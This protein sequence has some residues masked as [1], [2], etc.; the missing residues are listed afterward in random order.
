M[1]KLSKD[2]MNYPDSIRTLLFV[3]HDWLAHITQRDAK[4]VEYGTSLGREICRGGCH[5]TLIQSWT[6]KVISNSN[7]TKRLAYRHHLFRSISRSEINNP[8]DVDSIHTLVGSM[9]YPNVRFSSSD[10]LN[11]WSYLSDTPPL[12]NAMRELRPAIHFVGE[13]LAEREDVTDVR[14]DVDHGLLS[15]HSL[16]YGLYLVRLKVEFENLVVPDDRLS[17]LIELLDNTLNALKGVLHVEI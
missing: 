15:S 6:D 5:R 3:V 17:E 7:E 1:E 4:L 14:L 2:L 9:Y 11:V 10:L 16:M 13:Q 8:P 12:I